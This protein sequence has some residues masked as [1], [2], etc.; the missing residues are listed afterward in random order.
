MHEGTE[1][2]TD[3]TIVQRELEL[4]KEATDKS[5]KCGGM[6]PLPHYAILG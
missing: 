6:Q 1:D 3:V 5:C 2:W 4:W